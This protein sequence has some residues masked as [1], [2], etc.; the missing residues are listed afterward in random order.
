[1]NMSFVDYLINTSVNVGIAMSQ[2]SLIF[3]GWNTTRKNGEWGMVYY[4]YTN[5]ISYYS[6]VTTLKHTDFEIYQQVF[7]ITS[8]ARR[9]GP[10]H[11]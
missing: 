5:I 3:D 7:S 10:P 8:G 9:S 2:T 4:C 6:T 11:I 1:M